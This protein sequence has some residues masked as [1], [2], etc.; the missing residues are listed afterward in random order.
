MFHGKFHAPKSLSAYTS[1]PSTAPF[2]SETFMNQTIRL[3]ARATPGVDLTRFTYV[4]ENVCEKSMFAV[5]CDVIQRSASRCS[6]V[7]EALSI[8]PRNRPTCTKTSVTA[9][10]TPLTVMR[11]RSLS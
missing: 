11:K 9:K 4:S 10:A 1:V 7:S 3:S 6:I 2:G 5:L 8:N